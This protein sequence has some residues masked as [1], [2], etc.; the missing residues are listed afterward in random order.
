MTQLTPDQIARIERYLAE[1]VMGWHNGGENA[2]QINCWCCCRDGL[3][4]LRDLKEW[5]IEWRPCSNPSQAAM[6][7][8][9]MRTDGWQYVAQ[10]DG[11]RYQWEWIQEAGK[12]LSY[13]GKWYSDESEASG[14]AAF[15]AMGGKL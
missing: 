3:H 11:H 13:R 8:E 7:R 9:K 15:L 14:V 12:G 5:L 1:V 6:V 10:C 4:T 2:H